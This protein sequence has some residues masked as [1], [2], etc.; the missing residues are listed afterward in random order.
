M[1]TDETRYFSRAN[2]RPALS[3][4]AGGRK[5]C[6]VDVSIVL[7]M[8]GLGLASSAGDLGFCQNRV[9]APLIGLNK[10]VN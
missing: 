2:N 9:S 8:G 1:L 6:L 5:S 3:Q 4:R 10:E 7:F